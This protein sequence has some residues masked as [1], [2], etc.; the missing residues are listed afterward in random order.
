MAGG[1]VYQSR[2]DDRGRPATNGPGDDRRQAKLSKKGPARYRRRVDVD[3][4]GRRQQADGVVADRTF[5]AKRLAILKVRATFR[6]DDFIEA[7]ASGQVSRKAA[8]SAQTFPVV[9]GAPRLADGSGR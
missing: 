1:S 8:S 3:G 5:A 6:I 2:C 9:D 4:A 7:T